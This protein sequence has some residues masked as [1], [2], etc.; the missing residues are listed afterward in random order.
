MNKGTKIRT[1]LAIAM[2]FYV[3]VIKTDL[4]DFGS[5]IVNLIYQIVMKAAT[6]LVIFLITYYNNDYT[7]EM[8]AATK[9]GREAKL[10]KNFVPE[11]AEEPED[12]FIE[13]GGEVDG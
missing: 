6:F 5:D 13:E 10:L 8:D 3:A 11:Y 9:L 4:T 7:P 1:A 2:A 12:S